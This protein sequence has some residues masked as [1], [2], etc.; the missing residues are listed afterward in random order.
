VVAGTGRDAACRARRAA[1]ALLPRLDH[2][3]AVAHGCWAVL[4]PTTSDAL[5]LKC[6]RDSGCSCRA[7]ARRLQIQGQSLALF[8]SE[9]PWTMLGLSDLGACLLE[10]AGDLFSE[11]EAKR[12]RDAVAEG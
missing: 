4:C 3:D 8:G 6:C 9:A 1:G 12:G 11:G 10:Y 5:V 2:L 7:I